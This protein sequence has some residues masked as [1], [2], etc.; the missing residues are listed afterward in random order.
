[1]TAIASN[2]EGSAPKRAD[3]P[4][5]WVPRPVED[6]EP[7]AQRLL[8]LGYRPLIAPLMRIDFL[9]PGDQ[10]L[11]EAT[12]ALAFTSANGVRAYIHH[13]N[14]RDLAVFAVG[15]RTGELAR[16]AGFRD[17]HVAGGNVD[18]LS[19]MIART[20]TPG[21][22]PILH[23]TGTERAGDLAKALTDGGFEVRRLVLYSARAVD[24]LPK[25]VETA[26]KGCM[27]DAV[28]FFSPRTARLAVDLI[29]K[30]GLAGAVNAVTALC[31]SENVRT[32]AEK[33]VWRDCCVSE[34]PESGALI[35]RLR[36]AVSP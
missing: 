18:L 30:S 21:E 10:A 35:D 13:S 11:L 23:V 33:L 17:V 20:R 7:L 31:L 12:G 4:V 25:E 34:R 16:D 14:R 36:L 19:E 26:L 5:V 27:L 6:A 28:V 8:A 3:G 22:G 1:M 15:E 32:E 29:G 9:D 24:D 2:S